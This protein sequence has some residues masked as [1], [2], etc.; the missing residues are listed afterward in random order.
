MPSLSPF[1]RMKRYSYYETGH[2]A[3]TVMLKGSK[4]FHLTLRR[5]MRRY[6]GTNPRYIDEIV[7]ITGFDPERTICS[8]NDKEFEMFWKAIE[9][10]EN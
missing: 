4:Y 6:D 1:S 3:I 8:L 7:G 5:A 10:V 2:E 9:Q